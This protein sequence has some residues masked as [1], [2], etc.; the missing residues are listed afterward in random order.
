MHRL[1]VKDYRRAPRGRW[2]T[3]CH[4]YIIIDNSDKGPELPHRELKWEMPNKMN[5]Y[6]KIGLQT[7]RLPYRLLG[8]RGREGLKKIPLIMR[9]YESLYSWLVAENIVLADT[10][11]GKMYLDISSRYSV[12]WMMLLGG[13]Y[14][15]HETELFKSVIREGMTVVDLGANIG[16][17][18]LLAARLVGEKGRVFSFEPEPNNFALLIKNV[19]LNRY[20]NVIPVQKAVSDKNAA[21][22]L[23]LHE[24]SNVHSLYDTHDAGDSIIVDVTTLDSVWE[25]EGCPPIDV[26]KMDIEGAEMAALDGMRRIISENPNL[27][28]LT[29]FLPK[30]LQQSGFSA[31][32]FLNKLTEFGFK[33]Y[34][35]TSKEPWIKPVSVAQV[36][37]LGESR[38]GRSIFCQK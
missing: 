29:E 7:F 34:A 2:T 23:F 36:I 14:E 32:D 35:V 11:G 27:K 6:R 16:Y 26:I 4:G 5:L 1:R 24:G 21:S 10:P 13:S 28:I 22:R 33:L 25:N 8:R 9:A 12:G 31:I 15:E 17:Y 20:D 37:E 18:T 3:R 19:E 30:V 38:V